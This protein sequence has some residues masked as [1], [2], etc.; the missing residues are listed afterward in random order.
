MVVQTLSSK[1]FY[2]I[3]ELLRKNFDAFKKK[4][5]FYFYVNQVFPVYP[6]AILRDIYENFGSKEGNDKLLTLH[7]SSIEAWG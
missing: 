3:L 1:R 4:N 2:E 5:S 6:N 7:Y